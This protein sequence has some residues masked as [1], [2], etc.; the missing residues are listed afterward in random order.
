MAPLNQKLGNPVAPPGA[1][2][3]TDMGVALTEGGQVICPLL[4]PTACVF[5]GTLFTLRFR[6]PRVTVPSGRMVHVGPLPNVVQVETP[7]QTGGAATAW[8]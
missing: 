2:G 3:A 4:V 1:G 6:V 8:S 5:F 7:D